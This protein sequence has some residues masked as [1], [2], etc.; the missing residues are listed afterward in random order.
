MWEVV[1]WG[2]LWRLSEGHGW[3]KVFSGIWVRG[4]LHVESAPWGKCS[5][6]KVLQVVSA[7]YC[8]AFFWQTVRGAKER[9]GG[10][11]IHLQMSSPHMAGVLAPAEQR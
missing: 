5:R 4:A 7:H 6:W 1:E 2:V 3:V 8:G 11:K 9:G 10:T